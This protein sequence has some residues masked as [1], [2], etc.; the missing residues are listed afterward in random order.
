MYKKIWFSATSIVAVIALGAGATYALFTSN[1]ATI[2]AN[3]LTTGLA[4]IKICK[5][6]TPGTW[7]SSVSPGYTIGGLVP[8][9]SETEVT[10]GSQI[11][12]GNDDGDLENELGTGICDAYT[13]PEGSSD[14]SLQMVP[15]ISDLV[16]GD[17][18]LQTDMQ[19]RF[20]INGNNTGYGSLAFWT[21]NTSPIAQTFAPGQAFQV[22]I[23]TQL[24]SLATVQDTSCT[25]DLDFQGAQ[26]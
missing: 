6:S 24:S 10:A 16:C 2:S 11:Y 12:L 26:I 18:S 17:V 14:I 20:L 4:E 23:F 22:Q 7:N 25:F 19:L 1:T 3:T 8:G 21:T 13:G 5:E 9:A 15:K